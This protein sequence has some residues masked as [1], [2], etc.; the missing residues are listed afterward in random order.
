MRK[1]RHRKCT[2][3]IGTLCYFLL[4]FSGLLRRWREGALGKALPCY[5]EA[6]C[7][8]SGLGGRVQAGSQE[9]H[10]HSPLCA[11]TLPHVRKGP[12]AARVQEIAFLIVRMRK[13]Y[14]YCYDSGLLAQFKTS[15]VFHSSK[16]LIEEQE[17][18][19]SSLSLSGSPS[20]PSFSSLHLLLSFLSI[21][22]S[23]VI[24]SQFPL[25]MGGGLGKV[26]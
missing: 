2:A 19:A 22:E 6:H 25:K 18:Q 20:L 5:S 7:R 11:L 1:W 13:E 14:V 26:L 3:G 21:Q 10:Q 17:W 9:P 24:W 16:S 4:H 8:G 12:A 23:M 15:N